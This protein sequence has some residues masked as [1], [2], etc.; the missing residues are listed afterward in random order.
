MNRIE[1]SPGDK[2]EKV[3]YKRL[4][5]NARRDL[6]TFVVILFNTSIGG[7]ENAQGSDA[8]ELSKFI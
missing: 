8:A 3:E 1:S 5:R 6:R 4:F 7:F 2:S